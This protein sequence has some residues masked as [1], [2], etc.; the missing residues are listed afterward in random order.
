M[1]VLKILLAAV[2]V[3]VALVVIAAVAA[4]SLIP[5]ERSF[6]NEIEI[7]APAEKVWQVVTDRNRYTEWQPN[8]TRV[9]VIDD[10]SWIEYP[11]DSP[12][13]LR[14]TLA[15]DERPSRMEFAYTMGD[16]FDG[17]W[18]GDITPTAT[19]VRLK[20]VDSYAAKSRMMKILVG[21]FFDLDKFAKEWNSR[22]K[23]RVEKIG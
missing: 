23:E 8:L 3:L 19:G 18:T 10:K 6:P 20:T 2:G 11:K 14:F 5:A 15:K 9:E 22:L 16:S 13:P 12:E 17:R 4:G 21:M 1:R 7:K